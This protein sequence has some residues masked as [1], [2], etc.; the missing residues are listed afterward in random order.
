MRLWDYI[1][2]LTLY[3]KLIISKALKVVVVFPCFGNADPV[4]LYRLI[5]SD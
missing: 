5:G 3:S 4:C 1:L 2:L